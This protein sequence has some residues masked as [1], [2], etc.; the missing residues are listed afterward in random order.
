MWRQVNDEIFSGDSSLVL[1]RSR[2]TA[3]YILQSWKSSGGTP[4]M[5]EAEIPLF[6]CDETK[7]RLTEE[8]RAFAKERRAEMY[9]CCQ[10]AVLSLF[11][12]HAML[13][14]GL[15]TDLAAFRG[16]FFPSAGTAEPF[17]QSL[18]FQSLC[19]RIF[20]PQRPR[21]RRRALRAALG[22]IWA[23]LRGQASGRR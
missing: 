7:G 5:M 23:D 8:Q 20:P 16:L 12:F 2:V 22:Q 3:Q 15:V 4:D 14:R 19:E 6:L 10:H 13:S 1:W 18:A 9:D 17:P 11:L 21:T